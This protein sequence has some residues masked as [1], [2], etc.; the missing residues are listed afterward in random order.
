MKNWSLK[1]GTMWHHPLLFCSKWYTRYLYNLWSPY[2]L[3]SKYSKC[4][5]ICNAW[6]YAFPWRLLIF[7]SMLITKYVLL[8]WWT[9]IA[10]IFLIIIPLLVFFSQTCIS[11]ND[12]TTNQI[13]EQQFHKNYIQQIKQ[14]PR[15]I[16]YLHV[17]IDSSTG[18]HHQHTIQY[19][20]AWIFRKVIFIYHWSVS[21]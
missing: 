8:T 5:S 11:I 1:Q 20:L 15:S 6:G 3:D 12:D 14:K 13:L 16:E 21:V 18:I 19:W 7:K 2:S 10:F 9:N 4:S 17:I